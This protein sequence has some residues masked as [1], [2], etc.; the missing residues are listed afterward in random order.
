[1][2]HGQATGRR[3]PRLR[4]IATGATLLLFT[5]LTGGVTW[6]VSFQRHE[7]G[8]VLPTAGQSTAATQLIGATAASLARYADHRA[9]IADGYR[10]FPLGGDTVHYENERYKND[11][12]VLDPERP[13]Q[14]V[15]VTTRRGPVLVGAGYVMPR[16]GVAGP[17]P[18]G[19]LT[20]WHAHDLC[21]SPVPPFFVGV[22]ST[23][24]GCP[25]LSVGVRG[26]QMMH[27]WLVE[28]PGGPFADDLDKRVVQRLQSENSDAPDA[29]GQ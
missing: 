6:A 8:V 13:E 9:A 2:P 12:R 16:A 22:Q 14:L 26:P 15:Y 7:A 5:T 27:V 25:P 4:W 1:M 20:E 28:S 21:V 3:R 24:G 18:G 11:G 19:P 23:L 17:E 29:E 10:A